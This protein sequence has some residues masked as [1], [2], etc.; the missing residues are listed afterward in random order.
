MTAR[1]PQT[2]ALGAQAT[3]HA[4]E[5]RTCRPITGGVMNADLSALPLVDLIQ[6]LADGDCHDPYLHTGPDAF[7]YEP[8]F[9]RA[10]REDVAI[11][12]CRSC[13]VRAACLTYALKVRP[14][15]GIWA[16]YR[17]HELA[18][19]S[20]EVTLPTVELGEVA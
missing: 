11:E 9:E 16:G 19:L 13:P 2:P 7:E 14:A 15:H 6:Q 17:P 8:R 1:H 12:V 4:A 18:A 20:S 10:A 5:G 3:K